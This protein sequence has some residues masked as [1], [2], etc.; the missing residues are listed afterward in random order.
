MLQTD[1]GIDISCINVRE[2]LGL[3]GDKWSILIIALLEHDR[4]RFSQLQYGIVGISQRMLTRCLRSLER[5]G[6]VKREVEATIPPSVFYSLTPMG[7]TL[8][9]TAKKLVTWT[10][11][12]FPSIKASQVE[13]DKTQSI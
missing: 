5:N 7:A 3:V 4:K 13:F 2:V 6:L 9:S 1:N 12:N 10:L 11:E 8:L